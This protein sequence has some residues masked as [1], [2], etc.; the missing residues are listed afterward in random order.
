MIKT[1]SLLSFKF[2]QSVLPISVHAATMYDKL[3]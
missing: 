1:V 3:R 2:E